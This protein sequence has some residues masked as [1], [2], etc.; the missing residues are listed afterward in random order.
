MTTLLIKII[1]R[2]LKII[3]MPL[4]RS[5]ARHLINDGPAD[6]VMSF[7]CS[8]Q[9]WYVHN[10]WP[11]FKKPQRFSDKLWHRMLYDR[12]PILTLISDKLHVRD[13]IAQKVGSDYLMPLLWHGNDPEQIP[14]DNLPD[15]FV[16]KTNHGCG[17]NIIVQDKAKLDLEITKQ[18]VKQWL[19]ENYCQ[20][21][22]MGTEWGYKNVK[23]YIMIEK[24]VGH[25]NKAPVDFKFYC[26][27][28]HVEIITLHFDRFE[29][30]KIL[31]YDGMFRPLKCKAKFR[32]YN[33]TFQLPLNCDEMIK[34]AEVL[35]EDFD[36]IRVDLYNLNGTIYFG[37]LTPYPGGISIL[38]GFDVAQYD[39]ALGEKWKMNE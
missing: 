11:N 2:L 15:K 9:F 26:F 13:Y 22:N 18:K 10:F 20:D 38:N 3:Y 23:P 30:Q 28:G 19:G 12:D 33:G 35:S 31:A 14:F 27:A 6:K 34:L 24:F 32:P 39:I 36:F 17:Y 29:E 1:N 37:E 21:T 7:L 8:I 16:I 5:Y 25:K 4:C